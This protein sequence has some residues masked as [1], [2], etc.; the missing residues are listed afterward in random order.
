MSGAS[1][2]GLAA[3][4]GRVRPASRES[5][6]AFCS[7]CGRAPEGDPARS[8][9]VCAHCGMGLVLRSP[10]TVAPASGSSFL[11]VER[12]L[13]VGAVSRAAE[14]FLGV[15]ESAAVHRPVTDLIQPAD[16][17]PGSV[18]IARAIVQAAQGDPTARRVFVRPAA[19][20]G[21]RCAATIGPCG[22]PNAAVVVLED[23]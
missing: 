8:A 6:T 23:G 2:P 18:D 12:S 9:R 3:A 11:V 7:H 19:T 20:F 1:R 17:E 16:A 22:P 21:V 10:P 5:W 4:A 15:E 13:A 14:R